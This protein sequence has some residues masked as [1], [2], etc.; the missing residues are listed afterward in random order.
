MFSKGLE[1]L[2]ALAAAANS[3][4]QGPNPQSGGLNTTNDEQ[5][6][7]SNPG[8]SLVDSRLQGL[9]VANQ[10]AAGNLPNL[11]A[12]QVQH[13]QQVLANLNS[14]ALSNQNSALLGSL[15]Q[16]LQHVSQ[17]QDSS[18]IMAVQN[19]INYLNLLIQ[20]QS[21]QTSFLSHAAAASNLRATLDG[22]D[23]ASRGPNQAAANASSSRNPGKAILILDASDVC[24]SSSPN[25]QSTK[26]VTISRSCENRCVSH[27]VPSTE[28]LFR[29]SGFLWIRHG[30][31]S[32]A[33][34]EPLFIPFDICF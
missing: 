5:R 18:T 10:Q 30:L 7:S 15:C 34:F 6:A 22:N 28:T 12:S 13:L 4:G 8:P 26:R 31:F 29:I 3:S 11:S 20:A 25:N 1:A 17:A 2:A 16:N 33:I 23:A 9:N 14:A 27:R 32:N 24:R 21:N 19:Q